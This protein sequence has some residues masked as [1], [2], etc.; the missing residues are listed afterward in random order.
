MNETNNQVVISL[1]DNIKRILRSEEIFS[2]K[3]EL[4]RR[5]MAFEDEFYSVKNSPKHTKEVDIEKKNI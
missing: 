5:M 1:L 2:T 3:S 4:Y